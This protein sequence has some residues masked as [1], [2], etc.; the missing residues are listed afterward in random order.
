MLAK[1]SRCTKCYYK[2]DT[3]STTGGLADWLQLLHARDHDPS[4]APFGSDALSVIVRL[5]E[6][7]KHIINR[8]LAMIDAATI[9]DIEE[10]KQLKSRYFYRLDRKEWDDWRDSV[11]CRDASMH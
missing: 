3:L 4:W 8:E 10:I 5:Q 6:T 2:S 7:A 1:C 11:F 9:S